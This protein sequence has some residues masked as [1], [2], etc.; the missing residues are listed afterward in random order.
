M[1]KILLPII[2]LTTALLFGGCGSSEAEFTVNTENTKT[3]MPVYEGLSLYTQ[4]N[5][6]FTLLYP[7]ECTVNYNANDG[8]G[9]YPSGASNLPY[10]L[11][12]RTDK[13]GMTPKSYFDASNKQI[14]KTFKD[15]S[16]TP[17]LEANVD[18]KTL[19]MT[20]YVCDGSTVIDRYVELYDDYYIQYS[21]ISEKEGDAD[22]ELYTAELSVDAIYDNRGDTPLYVALPRFPAVTRD[23]ALVCDE[24]VTVGAL[25][26]VIRAAAGKALT[27]ISLFDI[28]RGP[29]IPAGK[30]STA[31]NLEFRAPDR[32]LTVAEVDAL[33]EKIL[34]ALSEKGVSLR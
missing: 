20:R 7:Q 14:L 15:V 4:P 34:G 1:K 31:F 23:L 29:G 25:E 8:T 19:Y 26:D 18:G 10:V 9:I 22:T 17:I 12:M 27:D 32:T 13:K 5:G 30:K 2:I 28:Y 24:S 6:D 33:V 11:V 21:A 3:G 16:S